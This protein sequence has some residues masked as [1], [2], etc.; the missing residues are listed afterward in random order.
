MEGSK[1]DAA[2]NADSEQ[3]RFQSNLNNGRLK[4]PKQP[5]TT[6]KTEAFQSNLNN[7]RLKKTKQDTPDNLKQRV[8]IQ[9]K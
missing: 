9:L 2:R 6:E 7:G 1:R 8:S 3:H 4:K 5:R